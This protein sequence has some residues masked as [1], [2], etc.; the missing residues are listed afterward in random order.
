MVNIAFPTSKDIYIKV[1]DKKIALIENYKVKTL[2]ENKYIES[3]GES[4]PV[5]IVPGKIKYNIELSKVYIC[6][7]SMS[8]SI[9]F[10]ELNNFDLVVVKPDKKIIYS[11][12]E[13]VS[14]SESANLSGKIIESAVIVAKM[15]K[16]EVVN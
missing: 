15:K 6:Q 1:N 16:V 2:R 7:N 13:W 9:N 14:L 10:Y 5:F 3:F 11:G 4:E 12:C 8:D